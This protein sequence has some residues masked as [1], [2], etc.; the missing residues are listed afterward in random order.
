MT[1]S[2]VR[3]WFFFACVVIVAALAWI[4]RS[5]F[6][7]HLISIQRIIEFVNEA[8]AHRWVAIGFYFIF[9]VGVMALP[10]TMF[11]IIGGVLFPFGVALPL[12]VAA[13]TAGACCS[14]CVSR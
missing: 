9:I 10:I 1:R 2:H 13:A 8:R 11:P 3:R 14:F 6:D 4:F 12:N 5:T 7:F